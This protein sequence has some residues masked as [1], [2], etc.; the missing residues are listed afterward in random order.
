VEAEEK[1]KEYVKGMI[2]GRVFEVSLGKLAEVIREIDDVICEKCPLRSEC[3]SNEWGKYCLEWD[4]E[5][6]V[7]VE[8]KV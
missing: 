3:G 1:Y 7:K 6:K 2:N 4:N 8:V 5:I